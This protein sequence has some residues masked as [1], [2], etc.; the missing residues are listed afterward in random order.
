MGC[1]CNKL[2]MDEFSESGREVRFGDVSENSAEKAHQK[3]I[4][5]VAACADSPCPCSNCGVQD[6]IL[7]CWSGDPTSE[8]AIFHCTVCKSV[9]NFKN[10][11]PESSLSVRPG[12]ARSL[13]EQRCAS[14]VQNVDKTSAPDAEQREKA[15]LWRGVTVAWLREFAQR[16]HDMKTYEV[17]QKIIMPE[18]RATRCRYTELDTVVSKKADVFVS[19][20][21]GARFRDMVAAVCH[22]LGGD[23]TKA[24][25]LD[26]FAVRQWPGNIADLAFTNIVRDTVATILVSAHIESLAKLNTQ[27]CLIGTVK[28]PPIAYRMCA[29]FR[30]WCLVELNEALTQE[31]PVV[32]L[33]GSEGEDGSFKTNKSMMR[34]L[35]YL[36]DVQQAEATVPEDKKRIL[37]SIEK[38]IGFEALNLLAR[39]ALNGFEE[40]LDAPEVLAAACGI[41]SALDNLSA[42]RIVAA[43]RAAA[44]GG[45]ISVLEELIARGADINEPAFAGTT[46]LMVAADSGNV[47]ATK[48][49]LEAGAEY[50]VQSDVGMNALMFAARGNNV[51]VIELLLRAKADASVQDRRKQSALVF[52]AMGGYVA[53]ARALLDSDVSLEKQDGSRALKVAKYHKHQAFVELLNRSNAY[54][55]KLSD[56]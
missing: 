16:C 28:V 44:G 56:Q 17:V 33:I 49:L 54:T 6:T 52:A 7:E 41:T 51:G 15:Q 32:M 26:I 14:A 35:F 18:T 45:F 55:A 1:C 5:A 21:W 27:K 36:V 24:V 2:G 47:R 50:A 3:L 38:G 4:E 53:A 46:T 30:V 48:F 11:G 39:G 40:A 37:A 43:V 19:H 12:N 8:D 22:A 20:T 29:F 9:D 23:E 42:D 31:K 10:V 34:N 25:W 13:A